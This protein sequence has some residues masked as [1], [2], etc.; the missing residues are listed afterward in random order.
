MAKMNVVILVLAIFFASV[1]TGVAY[2][3]HSK[4]LRLARAGLLGQSSSVVQTCVSMPDGESDE[5]SSCPAVAS[6]FDP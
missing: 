4:N 6:V 5:E 1:L 2:A 3:K